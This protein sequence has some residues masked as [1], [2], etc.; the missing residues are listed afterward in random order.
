MGLTLSK[1]KLI[2]LMMDVQHLAILDNSRNAEADPAVLINNMTILISRI[3]HSAPDHYASE[4]TFSALFN[5]R[6]SDPPS[7][8]VE[9]FSALLMTNLTI[10]RKF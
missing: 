6:E 10:I 4:V 1:G 8:L 9:L 3:F 5:T 2:P 7:T